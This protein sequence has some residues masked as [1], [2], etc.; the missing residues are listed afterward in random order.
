MQTSLAQARQEILTSGLLDRNHEWMVCDW[1]A[2][3][4]QMLQQWNKLTIDDL[5]KAWPNRRHIAAVIERKYGVAPELVEHYL[6]NLE[7]TLPLMEL[8][9]LSESEYEFA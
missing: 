5:R 8:E 2:L 9:E 4:A 3:C 1:Q 7:R 6:S